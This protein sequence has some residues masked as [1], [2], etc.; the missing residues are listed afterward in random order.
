VTGR[1][2]QVDQELVSVSL[3][4]DVINILLGELEV[5]GDGGRLDSD[6]SLL[7]VISGVGESHVTGLGTSDNTGLGDLY[8][9]KEAIRT[10]IYGKQV[11]C[12]NLPNCR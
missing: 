4:L 6:T 10:V 5:H 11:D 8:I 7:L 9:G 2:D 1:I 3:L 12:K